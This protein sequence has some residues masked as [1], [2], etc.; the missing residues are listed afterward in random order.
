MVTALLPAIGAAV[1]SLWVA[2][3]VAMPRRPLPGNELAELVYIRLLGRHQR[4]ALL[5]CAVTALAAVTLLGA[6]TRYAATDAKEMRGEHVICIDQ[7]TTP[8]T[9]FREVVGGWQEEQ[10]G[11]DGEW[12]L[13]GLPRPCVPLAEKDRAYDLAQQTA[14]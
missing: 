1:V 7:A 11:T 8:T 10:L 2:T 13:V 9:C 14:C 12:H 4:V 6:L 5:A 3:L